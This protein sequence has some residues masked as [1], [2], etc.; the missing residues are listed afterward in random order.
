MGVEL[1][2]IL[3]AILTVRLVLAGVN[4]RNTSH[5]KRQTSLMKTAHIIQK[6]RL[7]LCLFMAC[8][9]GTWATALA[10]ETSEIAAAA[11]IR[12]VEVDEPGGQILSFRHLADST[13]VQM[14][15][16]RIEPSA[17]IRMKVESRPGFVEIDINRGAIRGLQPARRFGEDYLTY[18]LWAVSVDGKASVA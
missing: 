4:R 5:K 1:I 12:S 6:G 9:V 3:I 7:P 2:S 8:C 18:V 16:S 11:E 15:G 10:Q 17:S 13:D 14:R